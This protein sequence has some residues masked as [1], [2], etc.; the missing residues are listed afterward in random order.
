MMTPDDLAV[1]FKSLAAHLATEDVTALLGAVRE[2]AVA[3]GDVVLREGAASDTLF[4]VWQGELSVTVDGAGGTLELGRYA[5]GALVGEVSLLDRGPVS[6]T[7][8]A[9]RAGTLLALGR[10]DLEALHR[11]SPRAATALLR[12]L[13]SALARRVRDSTDHLESLDADGTTKPPERS[14]LLGVL[15]SLFFTKREG[16]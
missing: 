13:C 4:L 3:V 8:T 15:R 9:T 12:V 10:D 14:S 2:R 16:A 7:V 6:A 11:G 1:R 5:E